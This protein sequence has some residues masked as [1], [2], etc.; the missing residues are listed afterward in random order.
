MEGARAASLRPVQRRRPTFPLWAGD[1]QRGSRYGVS[2][3]GGKTK[4]SSCVSAALCPPLRFE[5]FTANS[6]TWK[7]GTML[8]CRTSQNQRPHPRCSLLLTH[9]LL[10]IK[11]QQAG[12]QINF[13]VV[14]PDAR[15]AQKRRTIGPAAPVVFPLVRHTH[16]PRNASGS[17]ALAS[18]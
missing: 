16:F 17:V 2:E 13:Q 5:Q 12:H 18:N 15:S 8:V 11:G 14:A 9:A 7:S 1:G 4:G 3:A 10:L 6:V